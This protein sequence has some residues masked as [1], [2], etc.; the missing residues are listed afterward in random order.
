MNRRN[1]LHT[2][3][4]SALG[5]S[6]PAGILSLDWKKSTD[7]HGWLQQLASATAARRRSSLFVWSQ[8]LRARMLQT[9]TFL[10]G[11]GYVLEDTTVYFY[12]PAQD[13]CFYPLALRH[14]P[15]GLN[16]LLVPVLGRNAEGQWQQ[17]VV[18]TGYQVEALALAAAAL[19][20]KELPLHELLLPAGFIPHDGLSY[21]TSRGSVS[22]ET[23]LHNGRATTELR[24]RQGTE[25]LYDGTFISQHCLST[26]A[27]VAA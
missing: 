8:A 16:D 4:I 9:N 1:F 17:L 22:M 15:T 25:T 23:R 12:A 27:T 21:I 26:A 7:V 11:R 18:L 6:L 3:S 14:R 5:L 19:A 10:A 24:V 2:G 20:E 13:Y